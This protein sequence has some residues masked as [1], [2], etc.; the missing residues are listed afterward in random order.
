MPDTPRDLVFVD[1]ETLGL[2]PDAPVWEFAALRRFADGNTDQTQFCIRH[3]TDPWAAQM[4]DQA[5]A[6]FD[7]YR[8]RYTPADA[9]DEQSA[10]IMI[11]MVTR[12]AIVV[13]CNPG[14]DT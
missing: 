1:T 4:R 10:A 6:F 11:H 12:D 2:D 5:P 13:G 7:D 9:L 14:F 3:Q 8:A